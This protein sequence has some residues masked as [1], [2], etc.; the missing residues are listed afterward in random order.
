M[1]IYKKIKEKNMTF[2][3]VN[4]KAD[5]KDNNLS[6]IYFDQNGVMDLLAFKVDIKRSDTISTQ[7]EYQF[8]NP[9]PEHI[10]EIIDITQHLS[11]RNKR[12]LQKEDQDNAIFL[13]LPISWKQGQLN[14]INE[15]YN[16]NISAFNSSSEFYLDVCNKY[17]TP[18]NGDIY[19]QNRKE[20]YYPDEKFCEENCQFFDYNYNTAKITCKCTPKK[21]LIIMIKLLLNTMIKMKNLKK[22]LLLPILNLWDVVQLYQKH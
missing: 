15:L 1:T 17:T 4:Y 22:N 20:E 18:D 13:D 16:K 12:R 7:V 11:Q 10:D 3:L 21:I 19:L 5:N 9:D 14:K 8:Y 2:Y 6:K